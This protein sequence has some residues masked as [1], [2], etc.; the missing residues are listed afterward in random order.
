[1]WREVLRLYI[2]SIFSDLLWSNLADFNKMPRNSSFCSAENS[3]NDILRNV[4]SNPLVSQ[5][6]GLDSKSGVKVRF[7]RM[8]PWGI[9]SCVAVY[10]GYGRVGEVGEAEEALEL[11]SGD[12]LVDE[13][14]QV[15]EE[16]AALLVGYGRECRG[17]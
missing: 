1:V 13:F 6:S 12:G 7:V 15:P 5:L 14:L 3:S 4:S 10:R 11:V 9:Q 2:L 8:H 17:Q 16:H